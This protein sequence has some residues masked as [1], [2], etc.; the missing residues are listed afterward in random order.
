MFLVFLIFLALLS[1]N[2]F[3][4]S[5]IDFVCLTSDSFTTD[6]YFVETFTCCLFTIN[7]NFCMFVQYLVC[8][9]SA[10]LSVACYDVNCRAKT[11]ACGRNSYIFNKEKSQGLL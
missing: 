6:Q 7:C 8:G 1:E 4:L 11:M 3:S 5:E 2:G 9:S 10:P